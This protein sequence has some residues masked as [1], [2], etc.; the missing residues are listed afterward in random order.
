MS[1]CVSPI[2]LLYPFQFALVV[3][4]SKVDMFFSFIDF[5]KGCIMVGFGEWAQMMPIA[6]TC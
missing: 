1:G 2:R 4:G 6:D 5:V 3:C